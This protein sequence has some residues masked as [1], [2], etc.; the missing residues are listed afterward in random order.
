MGSNKSDF[1]TALIKELIK[2]STNWYGADNWDHARFG[3]YHGTIKSLLVTK[4]NQ[5]FASRIALVPNYHADVIEGVS[6]IEG[7]VEGLSATYDL[8][9]DESSKALLVKLFAY[10]IMGPK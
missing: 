6:E 8:L 5:S 10:R 3:P 9:A 2:N 1:S 4:F 7:L